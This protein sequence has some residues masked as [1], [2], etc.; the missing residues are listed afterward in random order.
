MSRERPFGPEVHSSGAWTSREA[1]LLALVCLLAGGALGYLLRGSSS[2]VPAAASV[3]ASSP[4]TSAPATQNSALNLQPLE[5]TAAPLE[6][7]LKT[8]PK[9][10]DLLIQLGNLY[11]DHQSY[12]QAIGY[13]RRALEL[14]PN[15]VNVRTDMGTAYWYSGNAQQ[16]VSEYKKSLALDPKHAQTLFNLGVVYKDGLK[17]PALALATWEKLLSLYPQHADR[18]RIESLMA[19]ARQEKALAALP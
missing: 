18:A 9:N 1:Y 7:A 5:T 14:R 11:Y 15:D 19:S 12:S 17:N 2:P 6:A 13:Y 3:A 16:A 10:A 8:D 4:A